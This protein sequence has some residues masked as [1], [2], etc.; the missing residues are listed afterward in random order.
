MA[1]AHGAM[2]ACAGTATCRICCGTEFREFLCAIAA[3]AI[4]QYLP[5]FPFEVEYPPAEL[6]PWGTILL[7]V[8]TRYLCQL[9]E[10]NH[11][12]KEC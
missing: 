9:L 10:R 6:Q 5:V 4:P 12:S 1:T 8:F 3:I 11:I 7:A 2:V